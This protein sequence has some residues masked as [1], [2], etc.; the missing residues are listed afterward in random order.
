MSTST[1]LEQPPSATTGRGIGAGRMI[2][3]SMSGFGIGCADFAGTGLIAEVD[4]LGSLIV[5]GDLQPVHFNQQHGPG[6]QRKAEMKGRF[7]GFNNS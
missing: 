3:Y 1:S 2:L 7:D 5:N 4:N 6:I